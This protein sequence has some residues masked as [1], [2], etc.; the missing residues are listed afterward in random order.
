MITVR[1]VL[2]ED[3]EAI[4]EV[5]N[6]AVAIL[7]KAYR[8]KKAVH[9]NRPHR[10]GVRTGLVALSDKR[11]VGT[12]QYAQ[13]GDGIHLVGLFVHLDFQR[14]GIAHHLV[15]FLTDIEHQNEVR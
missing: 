15:Q 6:L 8:P 11:V 13:R 3:A 10:E 4:S 2:P 9:I 1:V 14:Q 7:R 12:V 5:S